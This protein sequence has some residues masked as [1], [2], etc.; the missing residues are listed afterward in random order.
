MLFRNK[1]PDFDNEDKTGINCLNILVKALKSLSIF[2][3]FC[4]VCLARSF[5]VCFEMYKSSFQVMMTG[6]LLNPEKYAGQRLPK[7]L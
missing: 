7:R 1:E 5:C 3:S 6:H 4:I 2:V